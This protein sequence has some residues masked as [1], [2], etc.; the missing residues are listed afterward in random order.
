M[1]LCNTCKTVKPLS[2]FGLQRGRPRHQCKECKRQESR[3]WYAKNIDKKKA[4]SRAYKYIKKDQDLRKGYGIS[5]ADYNKMLVEQS[6]CCK[7]CQT[8]RD[9]LKRDL[10]VDHN[11]VTGKVRGLL[12][13]TCNRSLGLLKDNLTVLQSAVKYLQEAL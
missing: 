4:L 6:G 7:I 9:K 12:C 1:K 5:L 13:D 2:E 11:H 8:P 10:C 3:E